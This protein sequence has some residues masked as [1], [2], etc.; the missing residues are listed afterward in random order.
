MTDVAVVCQ[1]VGRLG[2]NHYRIGASTDA[3]RFPIRIAPKFYVDGHMGNHLLHVEPAAVTDPAPLC[4]VIMRER[5]IRRAGLIDREH[6]S[7]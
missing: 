1:T 6:G 5:M 7:K 4:V 3:S 2:I